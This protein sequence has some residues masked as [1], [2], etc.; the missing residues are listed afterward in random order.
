[1][2]TGL[3]P[4]RVLPDDWP[5]TGGVLSPS[6]DGCGPQY[7]DEFCPSCERRILATGECA[8]CSD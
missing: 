4:R 2:V 5:T 6:T 1:M 3:K 8:G 7:T